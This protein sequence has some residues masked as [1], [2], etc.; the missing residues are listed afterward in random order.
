MDA[1]MAA[2]VT[3]RSTSSMMKTLNRL[4][5]YGKHGVENYLMGK[6]TSN[7]QEMVIIK[8]SDVGP[9]WSY[10]LEEITCSVDA[11]TKGSKHH[12]LKSFT[13]YRLTPSDTNVQVGHRFKH[14]DWFHDRLLEKFGAVIPIPGLPEKQITGRFEFEFIEQRCSRLQTWI[15]RLSQ[16]PVIAQSEVFQHFLHF[17]DE[18]VWKAG[19]RKAEKDEVIGGFIFNV[20]LTPPT[21]LSV[22]T[23]E[24]SQDEFGCFVR[25]MDEGI[26]NIT[27][28]IHDFDKSCTGGVAR[29]LQRFGKHL[30]EHAEAF[31]CSG[32]LGEV[33][34]LV[35]AMQHTGK[36]FKDIGFLF[37]EH[38][39]KDWNSFMEL[40][41]EYKGLLAC[42]PHIL[43]NHKAATEKLKECDKCVTANKMTLL[44]KETVNKR[45]DIMAYAGG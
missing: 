17:T 1:Q 9:I 10:D 29:E 38:P 15:A 19:K 32:Y 42:F 41:L 26:R 34:A 28:T 20:M 35:M 25:R 12:G 22:Q 8:E 44:E 36:T 3:M 23:I 11:P 39:K 24:S 18:K 7:S 5:C 37:S 27:S 6:C 14:F 2:P 13:E 33:N 4:S 21:E 40:L 43:Q 30:V 45:V 16:H 31:S